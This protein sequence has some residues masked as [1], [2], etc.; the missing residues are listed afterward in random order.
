MSDAPIFRSLSLT[1][2]LAIHQLLIATFGG[3]QGITEA[4]FGRVEAAVAA[5]DVSMFGEDLYPDLP[6]KAAALF[7]RLVRAHGFSDGNKRVGLVALIVYVERNG[8]RLRATDDEF[9]E[10]TLAIAND[11]TQEAVAAWIEARLA[12]ID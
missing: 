1:E 10:L 5:P 6:A 3:M 12:R 11:E 2:V 9:Y 7:W 4:G 8:A